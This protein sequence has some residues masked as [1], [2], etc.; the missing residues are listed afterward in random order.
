M[1]SL[2]ILTIFISVFKP[3]VS[4]QQ[5]AEKE[6]LK[7]LDQQCIDWNNGNIEAFMTSY[8]SN[9]SL[10]FVGKNGVTYGYNNVLN[11]YKKSYPDTI[12]MGKLY[13]EIKEVKQLSPEYYFVIGRWTLVRS[14]G[15]RGGHYSLLVRKIKG[16]WKIISDHTS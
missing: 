7:L 5:S 10:M 14:E 3:E 9:D 1:K 13:F 11:N 4:A 15:D 12:S 16:K 6:I 8:W 2:L